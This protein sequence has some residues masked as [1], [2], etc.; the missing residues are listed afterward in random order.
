MSSPRLAPFRPQAERYNGQ[1]Y[2]FPCQKWR[3]QVLL[4]ACKLELRGFHIITASNSVDVPIKGLPA[5][6]IKPQIWELSSDGQIL[7]EVEF[8]GD[9]GPRRFVRDP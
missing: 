2:D 5:P 4:E 7:K 1:W 9:G 6:F 3:I 8:F